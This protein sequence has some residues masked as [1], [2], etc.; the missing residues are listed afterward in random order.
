MKISQKVFE[1]LRGHKI[2]TDGQIDE[3]MDG[4]TDRQTDRQGDYY[5]APMTLSGGALI[6]K[7]SSNH[8]RHISYTCHRVYVNQNQN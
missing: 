8:N 4:R 7:T 2:K 6:L 5:R 3:W 1:L